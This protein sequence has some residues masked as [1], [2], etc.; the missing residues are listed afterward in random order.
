MIARYTEGD[1]DIPNLKHNYEQTSK[2][3]YMYK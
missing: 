2:A 3:L 1:K